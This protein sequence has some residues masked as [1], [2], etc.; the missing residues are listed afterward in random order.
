LVFGPEL[1]PRL[2]LGPRV[3]KSEYAISIPK[4]LI[5][6]EYYLEYYIKKN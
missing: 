4:I 6:L 3:A 5:L 1:A 2:L